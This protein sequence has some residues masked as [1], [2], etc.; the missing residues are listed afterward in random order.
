MRTRSVMVG[1]IVLVLITL[2]IAINLSAPGTSS[3][4]ISSCLQ[5]TDEA[6]IQLPQITTENLDGKTLTFPDDFTHPLNLIVMP[7][8]REQ[9]EQALTWLKPF[10]E[11]AASN[12]IGYYSIAALPN[13]DSGIRMLVLGGLQVG[14]REPDVRAVTTIAFLENQIAFTEALNTTTDE[15][16]VFLMRDSGE[17]VWTTTGSYEA[18]NAEDFVESITPYFEAQN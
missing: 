5:G 2:F 3:A 6:C 11:I 17:I 18:V 9:Q 8:D 13:L 1:M 10:Q 4:I 14:V 16:R 12:E 15:L 7:F